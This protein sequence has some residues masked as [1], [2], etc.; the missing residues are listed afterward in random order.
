MCLPPL[1]CRSQ[2]TQNL[3]HE[4]GEQ[5]KRNRTAKRW[6]YRIRLV[7]ISIMMLGFVSGLS[8]PQECKPKASLGCTGDRNCP[9]TLVA[10]PGH[11]ITCNAKQIHRGQAKEDTDSGVKG[12]RGR[13]AKQLCQ[14]SNGKVG[15]IIVV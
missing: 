8:S 11:N 2:I 13:L 3:A 14:H 4:N 10:C 1:L 12:N 5:S 15:I 6:K 7:R 9:S